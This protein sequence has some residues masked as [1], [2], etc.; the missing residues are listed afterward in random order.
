MEYVL[1]FDM[2]GEVLWVEIMW[3]SCHLGHFDSQA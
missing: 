1:T 2:I 3:V